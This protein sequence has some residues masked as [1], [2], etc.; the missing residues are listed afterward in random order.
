M[1]KL[2]Y[3]YGSPGPC[4][5]PFKFPINSKEG[6][7]LVRLI[8]LFWWNPVSDSSVSLCWEGVESLWGILGLWSG[9]QRQVRVWEEMMKGY[10]PSFDSRIIDDFIVLRI[11]M[12]ADNWWRKQWPLITRSATRNSKWFPIC[13]KRPYMGIEGAGLACVPNTL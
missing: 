9:V 3:L 6:G 5:A 2:P 10:L 1:D 4:D 13:H 7:C 8:R 12:A 11:F